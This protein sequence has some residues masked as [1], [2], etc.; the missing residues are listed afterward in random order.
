MG[1]RPATRA[2]QR[3]AAERAVSTWQAVRNRP[4]PQ[5]H[6]K[7][8][9]SASPQAESPGPSRCAGGGLYVASSRTRPARSR[10]RRDPMA[11]TGLPAT[12]ASPSC[13]LL[14]PAQGSP[15]SWVPSRHGTASQGFSLHL[16]QSLKHP[17]RA[18]PHRPHPPAKGLF[19]KPI[20]SPLGLRSR[21]YRAARGG[22]GPAPHPVQ[23]QLL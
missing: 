7:H 3:R 10:G 15:A 16:K 2:S 1:S 19:R 23:L 8:R 14:R 18:G 22:A 4:E 21:Q 13:R 6:A 12:L 20:P 9:G 17:R 11:T 5:G